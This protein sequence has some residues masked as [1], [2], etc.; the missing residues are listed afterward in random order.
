MPLYE[1]YCP[2]CKREISITQTIQEHQQGANCPTCGS[3][4]LEARLG[5]F[6]SKT[7]RKS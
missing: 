3:R 4:D 2:T 6:F 1:Y 7:S 5:T